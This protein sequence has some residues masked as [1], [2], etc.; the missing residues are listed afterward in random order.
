MTGNRLFL[1]LPLAY[2]FARIGPKTSWQSPEQFQ[3]RGF[4][5]RPAIEALNNEQPED[6]LWGV[7]RPVS[8]D[9]GSTQS[10]IEKLRGDNRLEEILEA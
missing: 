4:E 2:T 6:N 3:H 8:P 1:P 5:R 9:T 10:L 7:D